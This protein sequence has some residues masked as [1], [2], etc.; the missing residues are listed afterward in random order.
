[1]P[2]V[3]RSISLPVP[4]ADVW[5]LIGEFGSVD[6]WFPGVE[7][8]RL[9][10]NPAG[11]ERVVMFGGAQFVERLVSVDAKAMLMT[12]TMPDPPLPISDHLATLAVL[13]D[14]DARCTVTWTATFDATEDVLVAVDVAMGTGTFELGLNALAERFDS[15]AVCG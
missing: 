4:A 6:S 11:L 15:D 13:A 9:R 12:Y 5:R 2:T 14:D 8:L 3:T 7:E 10:E 1:M